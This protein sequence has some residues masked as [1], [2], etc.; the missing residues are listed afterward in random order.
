MNTLLGV[1]DYPLTHQIGWAVLHSLWQ[2]ACVGAIFALLRF[3]LRRRSANARYLA[4]CVSLGVLLAAPVLT[5]LIGSTPSAAP[6]SGSSGIS[7]FPGADAAVFGFGGFQRSYAGTGT[8][9]SWHWGMDVFTQVAPLLAMVWL[10]GVTIFSARLTRGCWCV[11]NIR[12]RDNEPVEAAWLETLNELRRRLGVS[13]PVRLLKSALVE[14]PTVIGWL[15][16]VILLPA[17]AL[18]GL[19]P[20]QLEA[21]LA[22]ELAHVR[23]LDYL[24]NAFQC[25]VETLMF[26]HPV[27]W[28]IS[29]CVREEREN[30]CDDLVI[31]VCG[32]RLAYARALATM[33]GLRGELPDLAFAASG[34]SL[35]NRIRR[36][37]GGS[38]ER[39]SASIRQLS[40]LA[41]LG[42]G[43]V[44][45]VLGVRLALGPTIYQSTSRIKI[46]R[47]QS[48][49][50]GLGDQRGGPGYDPYF[51]QTEFELLQS[52]VILGK[53]IDDLDLK[54]EWGKKYANGDRLKTS[55]AIG[56]LKGRIELR[57]VRNTSLI[58]IRV[59]SEKADEAARIANAIAEAY[60]AHRE[61]QR[62][63]LSNNGIKALE[64]RFAEQEAKV[65]KAQQQVDDL[66]GKLNINEVPASA[67]GPAPLMTADTLRKLESL[68]LESKAEYTRQ[69]TLLDQLKALREERGPEGVAEAIPTAAPDAVLSSL[70]E[71]LGTVEQQLVGL[72][73]DFGPEHAEVLKC[74]AMAE[75][76]HAKIKSRV[77]GIMLGLNARVLSLSNC[78]GNLDAE[79]EKAIA[80]DVAKAS[81]ARPY[82]EAKRNLDELQR[83]RQIL[84]AKI[85]N[86]KI[87]VE[88]PKTMMVEVVDRAVPS[89][90]PTSPNLPRALALIVLGVL[91]DIAGLLL[92]QGRPRTDSAP[93]RT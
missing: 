67:E 68:R 2:G 31:K 34:G 51:I 76:L 38:S 62:K 22:H 84:D 65:N 59:F 88:L 36:L 35:L 26:Y 64:E 13:R 75:D 21:L 40:G 41:L 37:L 45:I 85:A 63:Y 72:K 12:I 82:F 70:L 74:Q 55:E 9:S 56:L 16:P 90:R 15:R 23:R 14:V 58:E 57:P 87:A 18:G 47:D 44:L 93:Q 80:N 20:G 73:K 49:I 77:E 6:G 19:T 54:S 30:C 32:D 1:L 4:G 89:L 7:A 3:A 66:R 78:L 8:Y 52:E 48:D 43:L 27:A 71:K 33:E 25:L 83:F 28:W 50:S 61:E 46:E 11:R 24:V 42:I 81:Q 39:G 79:V 5:L 17:T 91:L 29:R 60:K 10:L 53:V 92:L 69:V 86:E